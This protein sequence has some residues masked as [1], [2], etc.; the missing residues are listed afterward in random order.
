[1]RFKMMGTLWQDIRYGSRMLWKSRGFTLIAVLALALGIGANTAIFSVVNTL[2][3]R[4]LA[5]R[6]SARSVM[7]WEHNKTRGNRQNV[8]NPANYLDWR[9]QGTVFEEI[10]AFYDARL[11]LTGAGDPLE[12]PT[13]AATPN[14]FTILGVEPIIGRRFTEED[15]K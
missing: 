2:L 13:Q 4:P 8:V 12:I 9:T 1:M 11:N 5:F 7:V 6:E 15:A 14:L 3:I 10:A